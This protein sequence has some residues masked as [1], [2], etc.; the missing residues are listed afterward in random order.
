LYADAQRLFG[1][2]LEIAERVSG[3]QASLTGTITG[4]M[5]FLADEQGL[6]MQAQLLYQR[7]L[8]IQQ[9]QLGLHHPTVGLLADRYARVLDLL[10]QPVE[11]GLFAARAASIR[12]RMQSEAVKH[13]AGRRQGPMVGEIRR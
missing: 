6:W 9:Q 10:G 8:V 3:P 1:E 7:A 5:A 12:A 2:A 13:G 11:A 4:N